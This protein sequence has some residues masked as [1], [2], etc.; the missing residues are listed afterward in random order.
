MLIQ[1]GEVESS[2][3]QYKPAAEDLVTKIEKRK[4]KG[5]RKHRQKLAN[6]EDRRKQMCKSSEV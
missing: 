4:M 2:G 5:K 3:K 1:E 6:K